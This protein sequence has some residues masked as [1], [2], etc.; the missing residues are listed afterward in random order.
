[1]DLYFV[2]AV[3]TI[4]LVRTADVEGQPLNQNLIILLIDGYGANLFNRTDPKIQQAANLMISK[5]VRAEYLKPVF[6]TQS[7]PNWF[8][9]ATGLYVENHNFTADFMYDD[10][11]GVYF[12][13]DEGTNDT[14]YHWWTGG[15]APL[16]YT[17]G[18]ASRDVHCYF[19][20]S[21]HRPH[22]DMLVQVP[23]NRRHSFKNEENYDLFA[24]IPKIIRHVKK[25]QTYRQ[26]LVLLRY[27]GLAKALK[28]FGE[29]SDAGK[30]ALASADAQ[31]RKVQ[32]TMEENSLFDTTNL[33]VMSDFGLKK[34]S[35]EHQFFIEECLADV[36]R[37]KRVVNNL[38][39]MFI[40]PDT[41]SEDTV[42][43]ELRVCDQWAP[44]GDYDEDEVPL[45][46]VYRKN[47]IP[48]RYHWKNSRFI[49]PIVL[50]ARPGAV[51]LTTQIPT[52]DV[53]EAH[54]RELRMLSGWDNEDPDMRGI[55]LAR[56]PAFKPEFVNPP[57]EVVDVYELALTLL[58]IPS[59]Q[60]HNGTW[61]NV[62]EM[63]SEDWDYRPSDPDSANLYMPHFIVLLFSVMLLLQRV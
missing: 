10:T 3:L 40:Y 55:F 29:D 8:S 31:I 58:G 61:S 39:Y 35:E 50:V 14:D 5:G 57:I 46:Q 33:I 48:D 49:A 51:L 47:D 6:P 2:L 41:D 53:S 7:Y 17:V 21:C 62:A 12:Q 4:L 20:A 19:F 44:M 63:L 24:H 1:M 59:K 60:P 27:N 26:Q 43:F 16:W 28:L 36:S 38:A 25:Y 54:G 9:L 56:G 15:P 18:K 32:E 23:Q 42:Y 45:V 22:V 30:Q 37:V 52:T 34:V 13:R 11:R